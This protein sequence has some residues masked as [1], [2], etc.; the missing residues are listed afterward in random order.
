MP[1]TGKFQ[2]MISL[3]IHFKVAALLSILTTAELTCA[4]DTASPV[5]LWKNEDATFAIFE[6][7]GKLSGKIIALREPLS[8]EGKD[9][10]DIHNPDPTKRGRPIIGLVFMSG[11]TRKSDGR[12]EN[13]TIYDPKSGITYSCFME[14]DGPEWIKVRG[15]IGISLL[16]RTDVWSRLHSNEHP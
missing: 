2:S 3:R 8:P 11:F 12:W 1:A 13:G 6:N 10:T 4:A 15:F 5:G 7:Q 16:G 14:L 9:K